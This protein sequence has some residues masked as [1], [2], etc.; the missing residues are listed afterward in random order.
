MEKIEENNKWTDCVFVF[1]DLKIPAHKL[2]LSYNS[3]VFKSMFYGSMA[4]AEVLIK[5]IESGDFIQML[6][7]IYTEKIVFKSINNAWSVLYISQ[8]YF[9]SNLKNICVE[10][11]YFNLTIRTLLLSYE[12]A[13]L[14][15]L[16]QLLNKCWRDILLTAKEVLQVD[17]HMK[18]S[19]FCAM[20]DEN[21]INA[22]EIDLIEAAIKW[23]EDECIFQNVDVTEKNKLQILINSGILSRLRFRPLGK[24][25]CQGLYRLLANNLDNLSDCSVN[26]IVVQRYRMPYHIRYRFREAYKIERN[27]VLSNFNE[28]HCL[29]S[30]GH[31]VVMYG[32]AVTPPHKDGFREACTNVIVSIFDNSGVLLSQAKDI[33]R[34]VSDYEVPHLVGLPNGVRFMAATK[35]K[36]SVTYLCDSDLSQPNEL[37]CFYLS[38]SIKTLTN[39]LSIEF[40]DHLYG[41]IVR[42]MSFYVF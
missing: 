13:I 4:S 37:L 23:S 9:I 35:Y 11:I 16:N 1:E 38:C 17:Y 24:H 36:I 18:A 2:V 28:F 32:V 7:F 6:E 25:L 21:E 27:L 40:D 29:I 12:Y 42:G 20:L 30:V 34:M 39:S 22:H 31:E 5:D 26:T 19:T 14:Y 33:I 3:P 10:F 8:K 41:G 15:N